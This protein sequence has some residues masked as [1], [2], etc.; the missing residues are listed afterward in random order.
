MMRKRNVLIIYSILMILVMIGST[1]CSLR[2]RSPYVKPCMGEEANELLDDL[3]D[4]GELDS[5]EGESQTGDEGDT[6]TETEGNE[7]EEPEKKVSLVDLYDE[8]KLAAVDWMLD[9]LYPAATTD[10]RAKVVFFTDE[11]GVWWYSIESVEPGWNE[12]E[13]DLYGWGHY[14]LRIQQGQ[15]GPTPYSYYSCYWNPGPWHTY[16][17][18]AAYDT[19]YTD[20]YVL[21]AIYNGHIPVETATHPYTYAAVLDTDNDPANNFNAQSPY[22]WDYWQG[23][24]TWFTWETW[25]P[26]TW[27]ASVFGENFAPVES[28]FRTVVYGDTIFWFIPAVEVSVS[29]FGY[30]LTG[31]G[32]DGTFAPESSGGDLTGG[33]PVE[34]LTM[35]TAEPIWFINTD[36][37]SIVL[38]DDYE[39]CGPGVCKY[40]EKSVE[41]QKIDLLC[42]DDGCQEKYG[43]ECSLF[44]RKIG[45]P[46]QDP[47]SW[48]YVAGSNQKMQKDWAYDYHCYCVK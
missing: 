40:N 31:F 35:F 9:S 28:G 46:P 44:Q 17:G 14:Y 34:P 13:T 5:E 1:S 19:Q 8:P 27:E 42:T 26:P 21:Q 33:A 4:A 16:C 23:T 30:R 20:W 48:K 37:T 3:I 45:D 47:D 6:S 7:F 29:D 32:H 11:Q 25:S 22:N 38:D 36:F 15:G 2:F 39:V 18:S 24:D 43:G 12:L 41:S 10:D